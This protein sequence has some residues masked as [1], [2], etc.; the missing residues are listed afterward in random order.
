MRK[1][2]DISFRFSAYVKEYIYWVMV[3]CDTHHGRGG[4]PHT[5][6]Q[7]PTP[8]WGKMGEKVGVMYFFDFPVDLNVSSIFLEPF[9]KYLQQSHPTPS[10]VKRPRRVSRSPG[11]GGHNV[12]P[13]AC[14]PSRRVDRREE[15]ERRLG[16][17]R[18]GRRQRLH[19]FADPLASP[20]PGGLF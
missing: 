13:G 1:R 2:N 8:I 12:S 9:M 3:H 10:A 16:E 15:R 5:T 7:R 11:P 20:P 17:Y 4:N 14:A 18:R 6:C 19:L